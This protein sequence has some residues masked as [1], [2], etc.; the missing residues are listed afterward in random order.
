M[1]GNELTEHYLGVWVTDAP[2]ELS[3]GHSAV[4]T[5]ILMYWPDEPYLDVIP[6]ATFTLRE[7][8]NIVGFGS[9][10][11]PR[12]QIEQAQPR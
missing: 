10:T 9:V 7:G 2:D 3:P 11:S 5:L 1:R 8:G 12:M 4:V 6:G